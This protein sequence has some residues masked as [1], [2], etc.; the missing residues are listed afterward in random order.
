MNE[1]MVSIVCDVF[2]HEHYLRQCL[3]GI[4][5]QQTNFAFEILIHDDASTDKS[6]E[7]IKEYV[8]KYPHLFKPIYQKENKFSKGISIWKDIQFPRAKIELR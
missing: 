7:I 2:N 4:V 1:I 8:D 3:D 5:M 6:V